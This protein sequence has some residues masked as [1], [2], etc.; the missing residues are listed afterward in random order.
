MATILNYEAYFNFLKMAAKGGHFDFRPRGVG[1]A[2]QAAGKRPAPCH[3]IS[4]TTTKHRHRLSTPNPPPPL[5]YT[6]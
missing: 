2:P 1:G 4:Y 3:P 6:L 5:H